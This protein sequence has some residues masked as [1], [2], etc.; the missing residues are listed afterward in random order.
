MAVNGSSQGLIVE[1]RRVLQ[2]LA[3]SP[4]DRTD[5]PSLRCG[6]TASA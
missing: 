1:Q 4:N 2:M 3:G 5:A 6:R